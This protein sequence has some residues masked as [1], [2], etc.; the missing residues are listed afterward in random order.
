MGAPL[1]PE[2]H[3][4]PQLEDRMRCAT[5][6]FVCGKKPVDPSADLH[7]SKFRCT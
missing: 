5:E 6:P 1:V 2:L 3:P 4:V 7:I